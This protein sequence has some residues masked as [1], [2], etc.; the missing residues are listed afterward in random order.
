MQPGENKELYNFW[1]YH[2]KALVRA[3]QWMGAMAPIDF[4]KSLI[5]PIDFDEKPYNIHQFWQFSSEN[6]GYKETL[7]PSI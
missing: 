7:H 1:G 3:G 4:E 6:G 2:A 5:S